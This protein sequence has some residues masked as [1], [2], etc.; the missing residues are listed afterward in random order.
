MILNTFCRVFGMTEGHLTSLL[1]VILA[2]IATSATA[3]YGE[4]IRSDEKGLD[5]GLKTRVSSKRSKIIIAHSIF[6]AFAWLFFAPLAI[7]V[8]RF[9]K[10]AKSGR[11]RIWFRIHFL[12]QIG[13]V[14]LMIIT[15]VLGYFA[16]GPG[17]KHQ[18]KNPHLQIGAAVFA[19][20][21]AQAL[22]GILNH[23]ILRPIRRHFQN[24]M[25]T[26]FPSKL[27]IV[28]GWTT[29]GLGIANIPIG[30]VLFGTRLR[31]LILFGV[32]VAGLLVLV[33]GLEAVK[34]R[35][36]G[37][38]VEKEEY[39]ERG[40]PRARRHQSSTESVLP[41]AGAEREEVV[42]IPVEDD[43]DAGSVH[44]AAEVPITDATARAQV[45][46]EEGTVEH[47]RTDPSEATGEPQSEVPISQ[48]PLITPEPT[49][50]HEQNT[51][52]TN[53]TTK[54]SVVRV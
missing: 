48:A 49:A 12:L 10:T 3:D 31:L 13:T 40:R 14:I 29:L 6:A 43:A 5:Q 19:A 52:E 41:V 46:T 32:Y 53:T 47:T 36:R 26:P 42:Y 39:E 16:V 17:S 22:S 45:V 28:L 1:L 7:V 38:I 8:A 24:P 44:T 2:F 11:G 23:F 33:F 21:L 18:F 37:V 20:T 15:F 9:F 27:H 34:G 35:D 30:M 25:K 51:E 4:V 54:P 50:D